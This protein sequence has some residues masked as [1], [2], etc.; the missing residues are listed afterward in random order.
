MLNFAKAELLT[1]ETHTTAF[2]TCTG[3]PLE[4]R[5]V[6]RDFRKV[7]EAAGL[8]G[9]EWAP[10]ELRH[11]FVSLLSDARVPIENISR[12]VGHRSTM[13]TETIYRKLLRPVIEGGAEVMDR[14]FPMW[15]DPES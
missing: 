7:V 5:N 11:S 3:R 14:I 15:P 8:A 10:R 4:A 13:V 12:L 9:T 2:V 1:L 6:R